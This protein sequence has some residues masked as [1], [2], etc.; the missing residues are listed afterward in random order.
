MFRGSIP[1][2]AQNNNLNF[3]IMKL[4]KTDVKNIFIWS[5][6]KNRDIYGNPYYAYV[7]R[8]NLT[9]GREITFN[10]PMSWGSSG[11]YDVFAEVSQELSAKFGIR[12]NYDDVRSGF[13]IQTHKQVKT[14]SA[15][16]HPERWRLAQ[17]N[18]I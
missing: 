11:A 5:R 13:V 4:E 12:L 2:A 14:D 10:C 7:C 6:G 18:A 3:C 17:V 15:L 8:I 16:E 1:R 9:D